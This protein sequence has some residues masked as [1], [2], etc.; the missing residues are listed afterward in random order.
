M[1][2]VVVLLF[3]LA[4]GREGSSSIADESDDVLDR[5]KYGFV[6]SRRP[7]SGDPNGAGRPNWPRYEA[8]G[9]QILDFANDGAKAG[10]D[11]WKARLDLVEQAADA[12]KP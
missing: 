2:L 11:P 10:P 3:L 9:D 5:S 7:D 4:A 8:K 1:L 12:R 6:I